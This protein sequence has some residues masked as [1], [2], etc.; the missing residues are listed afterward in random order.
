MRVFGLP[1]LDHELEFLGEH[2]FCVGGLEEGAFEGREAG[3]EG[4][5]HAIDCVVE[6]GEGLEDGV[7]EVLFQ[8]KE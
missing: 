4:E 6:G 5:V 3:H 7:A 2:V 1:L 8:G